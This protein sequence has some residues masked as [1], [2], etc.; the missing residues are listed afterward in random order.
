MFYLIYTN[1]CADNFPLSLETYSYVYVCVC[2]CVSACVCVSLKDNNNWYFEILSFV[3]TKLLFSGKRD[4]ICL[5]QWRHIVLVVY[6]CVFALG[7]R[8]L[9]L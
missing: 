9:E 2:V 7:S 6:V 1:K 8:H 4:Q 5:S 3:S